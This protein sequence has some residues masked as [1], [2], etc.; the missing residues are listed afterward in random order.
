MG[1]DARGYFPDV[2]PLQ[3]AVARA[4]VAAAE[5]DSGRLRGELPA[6]G[7]RVRIVAPTAGVPSP[8][9][10]RL[11]SLSADTVFLRQMGEPPSMRGLAPLGILGLVVWLAFTA[12]SGTCAT[13]RRAAEQAALTP[14]S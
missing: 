9:E 7:D 3:N 11:D 2:G 5:T 13:Q 12:G 4:I 14:V 10:A 1:T 8:A 6:R